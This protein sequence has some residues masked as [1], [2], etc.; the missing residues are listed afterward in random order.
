MLVWFLVTVKFSLSE[1]AKTFSQS[2]SWFGRFWHPD[3]GTIHKLQPVLVFLLQLAF[4]EFWR[5]KAFPA[6][7]KKKENRTVQN[8]K[9]LELHF[10]FFFQLIYVQQFSILWI[11]VNNV[12]ILWKLKKVF[13]TI[14]NHCLTTNPSLLSLIKPIFGG[15]IWMRTRKPFLRVS[16]LMLKM[17]RFLKCP[18]R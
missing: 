14:S 18:T 4:V 11:L 2:S 17:E 13:S 3:I 7:F 16:R 9:N 5:L 6:L 8:L 1:K 10:Y 15:K 12:V